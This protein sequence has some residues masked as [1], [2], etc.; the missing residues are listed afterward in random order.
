MSRWTGIDEIKLSNE[1]VVACKKRLGRIHVCDTFDLPSTTYQD[2]MSLTNKIR[3]IRR[4][5]ESASF[6]RRT[7]PAM[8]R[9]VAP[10]NNNYNYAD[11]GVPTKNGHN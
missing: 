1:W 9:G 4:R 2:L 8:P 7:L 10:T 3:Q 5:I 11:M 6:G